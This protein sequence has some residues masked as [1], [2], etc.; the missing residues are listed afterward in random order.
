MIQLPASAPFVTLRRT[1]TFVNTLLKISKF[2]DQNTLHAV[3]EKEKK[4]P[5]LKNSSPADNN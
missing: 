3:K 5:G 2:V 4:D 1:H